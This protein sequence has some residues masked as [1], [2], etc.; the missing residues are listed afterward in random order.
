MV[1][2]NAPKAGLPANFLW[3]FATAAYVLLTLLAPTPDL[4][5]AYVPFS[6]VL[7]TKL[8]AALLRMAAA[9]QYG[10]AFAK[11]QAKSLTAALETSLVILTIEQIK[12][13]N[14][15]RNSVREHIDSQSRG[16]E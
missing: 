15:S 3:G 12:I 2:D 6:I 16:P 11:S 5:F 4:S 8:K 1:K 14:C 13:L 10:T 9:P 7:G